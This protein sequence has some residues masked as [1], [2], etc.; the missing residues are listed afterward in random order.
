MLS[1]F[2]GK[3][4]GDM[5]YCSAMEPALPTDQLQHRD[6]ADAERL[7]HAGFRWGQKGTHTSRT[8]MLDELRSVLANCPPD[9][10]RDDYLSAIHEDN[11]LGKRSAATRRLSS[12]R[13]SEL[14]GLDP[15]VPLF[16]V[17]RR[18]WYIGSDSPIIYIYRRRSRRR[19]GWRDAY[20]RV[21]GQRKVEGR[22]RWRPWNGT[23]CGL[24]LWSGLT[25]PCCRTVS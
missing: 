8:V 14:Y 12:Q 10:T 1:F 24:V 25:I 15:D 11:C 16:R 6:D 4:A 5:I 19:D 23:S 3:L 20:C 22:G 17:M 9:A 7:R 2:A 13:L 21:R 18:C